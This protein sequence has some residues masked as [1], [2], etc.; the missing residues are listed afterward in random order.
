MQRGRLLTSPR[1]WFTLLALSLTWFQA[2]GETPT[3]GSAPGDPKITDVQFRKLAGNVRK[4]T[5][6]LAI[7]GANLG[8]SV[9]GTDVTL[10]T[11]DPGRPVEAQ[12]VLSVTSQEIVVEA[13]LPVGSEIT[14]VTAMI[15]ATGKS[16]TSKGLT[17]SIAALPPRP[18]LQEFEIKFDHQ[19]NK[20]FPNLHSVLVTKVGG[21]DGI[22]FAVNPNLMRIGLVPTGATDLSV[23]DSNERQLDLHFVAASDYEP[24]GIV[25]TVFDKADL[26][27]RRAL[28]VAKAAT[29]PPKKEDPN[30]P[31]IT[32]VETV[33]LDRSQGNGRIRIY[34]KGF[35]DKYSPFPPPANEPELQSS[36][37]ESAQRYSIDEFLCFCLERP[38]IGSNMRCSQINTQATPAG[39]GQLEKQDITRTAP[40]TAQQ[41]AH[42]KSTC[43][44]QLSEFQRWQLQ[45]AAAVKVSVNPRNETMRVERTEILAITDTMIDVYFEFTRFKGYVW[46]FRLAGVDLTIK[47]PVVGSEQTVKA[48][49]VS[50]EVTKGGFKTFNAALEIGPKRNPDLTF[51]YTVLDQKSAATLLG[52]GVADNFYVLQLSVVNN[53]AKKVVIPLAGIQAEVEWLRG[54]TPAGKVSSAGQQSPAGNDS[55]VGQDSPAGQQASQVYSF[56]EG[57]PTLSPIP[58]AEVSAYFDA[59]NKIKGWRALT[60]NVLDGVTTLAAALVHVTGPS[61][62]D[63][64]TVF[65][66]G[67][68]PGFHKGIG[69]LSSQQLQVLTAQSWQATETLAAKGGTCEKLVYLQR[70]AQFKDDSTDR[71]EGTKPTQKRVSSIMDLEI[72]SF[73]VDES[74]AQSA[75]PA[76]SGQPASGGGTDTTSAPAPPTGSSKQ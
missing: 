33:F 62:Q 69:D 5:F 47:K 59:H 15:K 61:F 58:L 37:H 68:I 70:N 41:P 9:N 50:G 74:K 22:G 32:K 45:V 27:H 65:T 10:T 30:Q 52:Y 12:R 49:S 51:R 17:V 53:G 29:T 35:G 76:A 4:A 25:V 63:A 46:P 26:D 14:S 31:T 23:F 7:I 21:D 48:V 43:E 38:R 11:K 44:A 24:K 60:F 34:G 73:E 72:A 2:V 3:G 40:T 75:T 67:F 66:G 36:E 18:S 16:A 42:Q 54:H 13:T 71:P 1:F 8:D 55:S 64:Y 56:M 20:E 39:V 19:K 28:Y 6:Q 57:P